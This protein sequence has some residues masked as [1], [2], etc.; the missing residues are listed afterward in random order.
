MKTIT[1]YDASTLEQHIS[2]A[3]EEDRADEVYSSWSRG[4]QWYVTME[5][6]P[7]V[8]SPVV[9]YAH[10]DI[11]D[12]EY[13]VTGGRINT[14][15][16]GITEFV[17]GGQF[18]GATVTELTFYTGFAGCPARY[19]LTTVNDAGRVFRMVHTAA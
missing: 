2:V 12:K 9:T 8:T 18:L 19:Y 3:V 17:V 4:N 5:E 6:A 7:A 16:A 11:A 1:V 13:P 10:G 15:P 14:W